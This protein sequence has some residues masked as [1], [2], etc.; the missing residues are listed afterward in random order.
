M[1]QPRNSNPTLESVIGMP[2]GQLLKMDELQIRQLLA[3]ADSLSRWLR[4]VLHLKPRKKTPQMSNENLKKLRRDTHFSDLPE[5]IRIP[6]IGDQPSQI[7]KPIELATLDDIAFAV[8]GVEAEVD[9]LNSRFY[10][11]RR[12]YRLAREKGAFGAH[13]AVDVVASGK[14]GV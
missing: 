5:S 7:I 1:N 2:V 11:L 3:K 6:P 9:A 12:L 13:N 4:G 10:A 8:I 14:G